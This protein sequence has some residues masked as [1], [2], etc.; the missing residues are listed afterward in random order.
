MLPSPSVSDQRAD[1]GITARPGHPPDNGTGAVHGSDND[2][3]GDYLGTQSR[4]SSP[5][6]RAGC[7]APGRATQTRRWRAVRPLSYRSRASVAASCSSVGLVGRHGGVSP[8]PDHRGMTW[9]WKWN[10]SCQPAARLDWVRFMP[11]GCS[12]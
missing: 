3:A 6:T 12:R 9:R 7:L 2:M 8:S 11:S 1:S 10:T 4:A 5:L